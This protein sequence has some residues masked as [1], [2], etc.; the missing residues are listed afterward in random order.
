M[1]SVQVDEEQNE[2][3]QALKQVQTKKEKFL[4]E[5]GK[6]RKIVA[7]LVPYEKE[8]RQ[9]QFGPYKDKGSFRMHDDFS[10]TES[11]LLGHE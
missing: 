3:S 1:Q 4:I 2:L 8:K 10:M 11:D 6:S 7:M 5:Y 9:R